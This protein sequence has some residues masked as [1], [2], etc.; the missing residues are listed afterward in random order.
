MTGLVDDR[1]VCELRAWAVEIVEQQ[2]LTRG[3]IQQVGASYHS[4]DS[5]RDVVD[6]D[7]QLIGED[8]IPAA[9]D[10]IANTPAKVLLTRPLD[11]VHEMNGL[12]VGDQQ[13]DGMVFW[14]RRGATTT[15][16]RISAKA[17][18]GFSGAS[19]EEG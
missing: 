1:H 9:Y 5:L 11:E 13:T 17:A 7:R 10:K 6:D 4:G 19:A 18:Q 2:Q 15:R 8:A 3:V 12:L 14:W 16:A